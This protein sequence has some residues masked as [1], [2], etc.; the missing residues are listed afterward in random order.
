MHFLCYFFCELLAQLDLCD[1]LTSQ[2]LPCKQLLFLC[3]YQLMHQGRWIVHKL[4]TE[5][6]QINLEL[7]LYC[8]LR[9]LVVDAIAVSN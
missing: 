8:I 7:G 2:L 1:H 3:S 4:A 5:S 9:L 6:T